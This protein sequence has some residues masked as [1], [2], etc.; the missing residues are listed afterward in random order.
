M[1]FKV[2]ELLT[3]LKT[4]TMILTT[5]TTTKEPNKKLGCDLIIISLVLT[6]R[7][8][9]RNRHSIVNTSSSSN[10]QAMKMNDYFHLWLWPW[11]DK[12]S[13]TEEKTH[14]GEQNSCQTE[15]FS[16]TE[17]WIV[18]NLSFSGYDLSTETTK[19]HLVISEVSCRLI[20]T[21]ELVL[22]SL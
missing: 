15:D 11:L 2:I 10:I 18:S 20:T 1:K 22:F 14:L 8:S 21:Y 6:I 7:A 5:D 9:E 17:Y 12:Y 19:V 3:Q 16:L 13:Q 4:T